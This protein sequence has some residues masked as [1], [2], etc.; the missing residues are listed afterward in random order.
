M[1]MDNCTSHLVEA[2]EHTLAALKANH[3]EATVTVTLAPEPEA[4]QAIATSI[5]A[6]ALAEQ[7]A[8]EPDMELTDSQ[9]EVLSDY[10]ENLPDDEEAYE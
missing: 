6:A 7:F 4:E 9:I 5:D 8:S 3:E 2:L 10:Y 1:A